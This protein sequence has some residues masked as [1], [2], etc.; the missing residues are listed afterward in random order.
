MKPAKK[1]NILVI[2]SLVLLCW[3]MITKLFY[4]AAMGCIFLVAFY[5]IVSLTRKTF[6]RILVRIKSK[7]RRKT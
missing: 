3:V 7:L 6:K 2:I 5:L 1:F 4:I